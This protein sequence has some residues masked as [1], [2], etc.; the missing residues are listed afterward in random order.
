LLNVGYR[1]AAIGGDDSHHLGDDPAGKSWTGVLAHERSAHAILDAVRNRRSY[2][3][4]GPEFHRIAVRDNA[5]ILVECS[6]CR[7]C[8]FLTRGWEVQNVHVDPAAPDARQFE[9]DLATR[10]YRINGYLVIVLEDAHYN[11]AWASAIEINVKII[12]PASET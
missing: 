12:A 11:R 2:A 7:A 8:Y 5:R 1:P 10:A 6:P 3:S 9:L 4:E